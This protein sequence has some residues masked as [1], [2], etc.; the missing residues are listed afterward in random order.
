MGKIVNPALLA[1]MIVVV[2]LAVAMLGAI[3]T[4]ARTSRRDRADGVVL[5]WAGLRLSRTE[6]ILGHGADATHIP[7]AGLHAEV[8]NTTGDSPT[9]VHL[10]I[11][12]HGPAIHRYR[13]LSYGASTEARKLAMLLNMLAA[14]RAPRGA[15]PRQDGCLTAH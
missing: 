5:T 9:Q 4:E 14:S 10:T 11:V 8:V 1:A 6:L 13:P 3:W 7:L 2:P 15:L 12:G